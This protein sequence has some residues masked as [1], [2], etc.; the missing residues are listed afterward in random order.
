[1]QLLSL[2]LT[3]IGGL[4]G[5]A[6]GLTGNVLVTVAGAVVAVVSSVFQYLVSKPFIREFTKSDW[7]E[8]DQGYQ[9]LIPSRRHL[10]GRGI[11]S[12]V[13]Q[14][15]NGSYEVVECDEVEQ[16]DGS[17]IIRASKPFEGRLVL[18]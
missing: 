9:V 15:V 4:V 6:G 17:F 7:K 8:T 14:F 1:M 3:I 13:S 11:S 2:T 12:T 18:K 16:E 5:L 10:R